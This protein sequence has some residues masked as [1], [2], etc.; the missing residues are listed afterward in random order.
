MTLSNSLTGNFSCINNTLII[1]RQFGSGK[2][3]NVAKIKFLLS[4]KKKKN[5]TFLSSRLI[6]FL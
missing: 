3:T 2:K 1:K 4:K 6:K 5:S